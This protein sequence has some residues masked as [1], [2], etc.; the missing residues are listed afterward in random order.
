MNLRTIAWYELKRL[1]RHRTVLFN[2]F[3]LPMLLI[4]ILGTA[5]SGFFGGEEDL[6]LEAL[7]TGVVIEE[8]STLPDSFRAFIQSPEMTEWLETIEASTREDALSRLRS[9]ELDVAVIVPGNLEQDIYS[10]KE[11]ELELLLGKNYTQNLIGE[12]LFRSYMD[13]MNGIQAQAMLLGSDVLPQAGI[14]P[15]ERAFYV[16]QGRLSTQGEPYSAVQYYA[17][18][19]MI[20]FLL[21]SGMMV[22]GSLFD[23]KK[24]HTLYRLQ[25][26]PLS[27]RD[28]FGGKILGCSFITFIQAAII[29]TGSHVLYGVNWGNRLGLLLVV[30]MLVSV[31]SMTLASVVSL[32]TSSFSTASGII[33]ALVIAM[34]FLSGGFSPLPSEVIRSIGEFTVNHWALQ[35]ILRMMLGEGQG[36]ILTC[37]GILG[38][39]ALML[40]A[41]AIAVYRKVGYSYHA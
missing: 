19:M 22:A 6:E 24:D 41:A 27:G 35:G 30:C 4:F 12:S 32:L 5:L 10:G 20:M 21:N 16:I 28:I 37:I 34:T 29:I 2:L 8:G 11:A 15:G 38:V 9:G 14:A 25:S 31:A 40:S 23:E 17:A 33:Q 39:I 13:E 36:E 1:S 3:L 7:R 18:S 26:L